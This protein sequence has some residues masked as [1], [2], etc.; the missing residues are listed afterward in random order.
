[1]TVQTLHIR[2]LVS[3]WLHSNSSSTR[4]VRHCSLCPSLLRLF[5]LP[6]RLLGATE[7]MTNT[8]LC[9]ASPRSE[10]EHPINRKDSQ[11]RALLTSVDYQCFLLTRS[12]HTVTTLPA[13]QFILNGRCFPAFHLS[14]C[15]PAH[16][17]HCTCPSYY[18]VKSKPVLIAD[19][20]TSSLFFRLKGMEKNFNWTGWLSHLSVLEDIKLEWNRKFSSRYG[21]ILLAYLPR[22]PL[23]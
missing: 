14:D 9:W 11:R 18:W 6:C 22:N 1:M 19:I 23:W 13:P 3:H 4:A 7:I 8:L 21:K 10:I 17:L 12:N 15:F 20:E 2:F 5:I 16:T